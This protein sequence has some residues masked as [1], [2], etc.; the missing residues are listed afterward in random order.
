MKYALILIVITFQLASGFQS[1][2]FRCEATQGKQWFGRTEI[3]S[4][5]FTITVMPS[6][7]DVT[8]DWE[9]DC[10][11]LYAAD[12]F[13]NALEIVGNIDLVQDAAVTGLLLWNG[14][15]I[16][17][18][19]LKPLPL[20]REQYENVVDRNV[21]LPPIPR[22]PVIFEYGWGKDNYDIRI[23]PVSLGKSRRLR[24]RYVVPAIN[25]EGSAD[26]PFPSP[27]HTSSGSSNVTYTIVPGQDVS[28]FKFLD[29]QFNELSAKAELSL[30]S[31]V[32]LLRLVKLIRPVVKKADTA[33]V[34]YTASINTPSVSGTLVHFTGQTA[35]AILKKTAIREDIVFLWR[36]SH[37]EFFE[38]YKKQIVIQAGLLRKFFTNIANTGRQAG[39]I[40][41]AEGK[42]KRVFPIGKTGSTTVNDILACLD[43]LSTLSYDEGST[44]FDPRFTQKQQDS[45]IS[46]S[47]SEFVSSLRLA[48]SL[49]EKNN[50]ILKKIVFVTAGRSWVTNTIKGTFDL[51]WETSASLT[52]FSEIASC[53]E[54]Q[55][56]AIPQDAGM[57]YWPGIDQSTINLNRVS[58]VAELRLGD[59][60]YEISVP[61]SQ[62]TDVF[63][64]GFR[65]AHHDEMLFTNGIVSS[66]IVWKVLRNHMVITTM[67]EDAVLIS[68]RDPLSFGA[69]L[70]A[71]GRL[72]AVN[73]TLPTPLATA[74]GFVD[75]R[76]ALLALE[77]DMMSSE[78]QERFRR[79][80]VP[81]LNSTDIVNVPVDSIPPRNGSF[82]P[83]Q[84]Q[85]I[86]DNFKKPQRKRAGPS[87]T[88]HQSLLTVKF[89]PDAAVTSSEALVE[90]YSLTG[91]LLYVIKN[92]KAING[93]VCCRLPAAIS[94]SQKVVIVKIRCGNVIFSGSVFM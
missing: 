81:P 5:K 9:L 35:E 34:I 60:S 22:D 93:V 50:N 70:A 15:E 29:W 59:N 42:E 10:N 12:S 40:I 68:E 46:L 73:T 86:L 2:M 56:A 58:V 4:E 39:L 24:I 84:V 7:I 19:K 57:F 94:S 23:F 26:I 62:K 55:L 8:L 48:E 43:S 14:D 76:Y 21:S 53:N 69:S 6:Y 20:A 27:F 65:S 47:I 78:D 32:E 36:W 67:K 45:I 87:V 63:K 61:F 75:Q 37:P 74:F 51:Q 17:K 31:D 16:L 30:S 38:H 11:G 52:L 89:N 18:A 3:T 82:G 41:D 54:L 66:E 80:G 77:D 92:A 85:V 90:I 71:S 88:F 91:K 33:S 28:D 49:F 44:P 72:K 79:T 25:A 13:K 64:R 83:M 1:A